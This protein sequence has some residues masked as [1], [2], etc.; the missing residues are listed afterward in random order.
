MNNLVSKL[1]K[2]LVRKPRVK[3]LPTGS[4]VLDMKRTLLPSDIKSIV[5]VRVVNP[6][7]P[8]FKYQKLHTAS[9]YN[10]PDIIIIKQVV[11]TY[12]DLYNIHWF[13]LKNKTLHWTNVPNTFQF[14]TANTGLMSK[15]KKHIMSN[16]TSYL[17][18]SFTIGSDPEIFVVDKN[19]IVIP[20]FNFLGSKT[21][22]NVTT[23]Y[24]SYGSNPLYW[25]GFQAEF[26][27]SAQNCLQRHSDS[28]WCGIKGLSEL[29]KKYNPDA[30]LSIKTTVDI[31]LDMLQSSQDEHVAFGCNPSFNAYGMQ[32]VMM[33]GRD[34]PFRSA[35]GH[36]HFGCGKMNHEQALP[37]IKALD[38]IVGV[39]CVSLFGSYDDPRRRMMYGLA[40]EYRLPPHGIEYR[41]LSNAWMCHPSIMHLVF[42]LARKAFIFG[43]MELLSH[44]VGTEAE[45]IRIIN[46]CDVDAAREVL[47]VN[48]KLFKSILNASYISQL[49]IIEGYNAFLNG[50]ET[51]IADPKAIETNWLID[52]NDRIYIDKE[53]HS[54]VTTYLINGKKIL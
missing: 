50:V 22:P 3:K 21:K 26:E 9:G 27:T 1:K 49:C 45:T 35:G 31:P 42:G 7:M 11:K 43:Q 16:L 40:G 38:A 10:F 39:A 54:G 6:I 2:K 34:V 53:W 24:R 18:H 8:L 19:D 41:V 32:G 25:D 44:W 4:V 51:V 46:Q 17:S 33:N 5:E 36:I 13:D 28:V 12:D 23:D 52:N 48:E 47:K 37:I 14:E 29:A 20:A 15:F 30:H